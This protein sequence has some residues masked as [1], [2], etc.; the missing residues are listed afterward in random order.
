MKKVMHSYHIVYYQFYGRRQL[1]Y[2]ISVA[3]VR[4]PYISLQLIIADLKIGSH[5]E[6]QL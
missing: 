6:L 1:R 4:W 2:A 3:H 5:F